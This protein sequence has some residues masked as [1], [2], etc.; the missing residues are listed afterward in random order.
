MVEALGSKWKDRYVA[1]M[2]K[3]DLHH[4]LVWQVLEDTSKDSFPNQYR[5]P[6][7]SWASMDVAVR[8][9][10]RGDREDQYFE[11][12]C[13]FLNVGIDTSNHDDTGPILCGALRLKGILQQFQSSTWDSFQFPG[14]PSDHKHTY[15]LYLDYSQYTQDVLPDAFGRQ[16]KF[17]VPT[18]ICHRFGVTESIFLLPIIQDHDVTDFRIYGRKTVEK[19][20]IYSLV[21]VPDAEIRGTFRRIG[22]ATQWYLKR[23]DSAKLDEKLWEKS[24]GQE[25]YTISIL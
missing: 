11:P 14:R 1:G 9:P 4:Y 5:A 18:R 3:S 23:D 13:E 16:V 20:K 24:H 8:F 6:S 10:V 7:W 15:I 25:T 17:T 22:I 12:F 21:L 19:R 2:W